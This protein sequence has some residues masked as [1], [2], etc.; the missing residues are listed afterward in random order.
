MN[1]QQR[2]LEL[3]E[4]YE[5]APSGLYLPPTA[6]P[7]P[8]PVAIDLFA[9]A[10]GFSLGFHQAGWHVAAAVEL[11]IDAVCT[12]LANLG[13]P[14]TRIHTQLDDG[15]WVSEPA[16][17]VSPGLAGT[18]WILSEPDQ[19]PVEHIYQGDVRGLTG[20][21]ILADLG[22]APGQVG[23]I[24]GGPP[25]QGFSTAGKRNVMDPRNSLIFDFA[26]L[27]LE[28]WPK[29]FV[30]E[31]VPAIQSMLTAEGVPVLDA[32][33]RV[34]ADGGFSEFD[35]L[36]KSLGFDPTARAGVRRERSG[37]PQPAEADDAEPQLDLFG[38]EV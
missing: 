36:R 19:L 26:R 11:E 17:E 32:F 10:G 33:A 34:L 8:K 23:A 1:L 15:T 6:A 21:Q 20:E 14:E 3:Y 24:I 7:T 4:G 30:M 29:T 38:A 37:K 5:R 9:G 28:V 31:N 22:M 12:Y 13:S 18:G 2:S 27:V 25:C 16:G 35:A